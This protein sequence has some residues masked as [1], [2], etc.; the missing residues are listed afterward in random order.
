MRIK[1]VVMDMPNLNIVGTFKD[2][3]RTIIGDHRDR[4]GF[5]SY[6]KARYF[7]SEIM[8]LLTEI[9]DMIDCNLCS[10]AFSCVNYIAT[11]LD[12]L[13]V[14]D[15]DGG[16]WVTICECEKIWIAI[17]DKCDD[18][19]QK[20]MFKWF[21]ERLKCDTFE[22]FGESIENVLSKYFKEEK[23]ISRKINFAIKK[24]DA[25]TQNGYDERSS[26]QVDRWTTFYLAQLDEVEMSWE[27]IESECKKYWQTQS[28]REFYVCKMI[29]QKNYEKTIEVLKESIKIDAGYSGIVAKHNVKLKEVYL[30]SGMT[31]EYKL[32]LEQIICDEHRD[33]IEYF[34]E[35]K[36][37]SGSD[38]LNIREKIFA[39]LSQTSLVAKMYCS[40]MMYERLLDYVV[41]SFGMNGLSKYGEV[42]SEIYPSE[43]LQKYEDEIRKLASVA[44]VRDMYKKLIPILKSMQKINGGKDVV[45]DIVSDWRIEYKRRP[46]MMQELDKIQNNFL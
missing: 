44:T 18:S 22:Y 33:S 11:R 4:Y 9:Y 1:G 46:A 28:S 24:L 42:L 15:S 3:L 20:S 21:S 40:E 16:T 2:K 13:E 37:A 34:N 23:W 26:Y 35:L 7:Y 17:L 5:I 31:E 12:K 14:D 32:Q 45:H 10:E 6:Y 38:W 36:N 43:I 41:T 30:L 19:L 39:K 27:E 25:L 8:D 29:E